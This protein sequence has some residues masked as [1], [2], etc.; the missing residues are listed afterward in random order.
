MCPR[1]SLIAVV[2]F[3]STGLLVHAQDKATEQSPATV[4]ARAA[5]LKWINSYA[6]VQVLFH[7]KDVERVR[8]KL[9][10]AS[11]EQAQQWL[12]ETREIREALDSARWKETQNWLRKF[13]EVQAIYSDEHIDHFRTDT[14][15]VA[16]ESKTGDP[17][18]FIE[19]LKDIEKKRLDLVQGAASS[20]RIR[21]QTNA[22]AQ[23]YR[24]EQAKA[25]D[26]ARL[27]TARASAQN[28]SSQP[29]V[30]RREYQRPSKMIDS[31]DVARWS[32]MR[33]FWPNRW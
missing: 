31:L 6:K 21:E 12:V 23:A 1:Q 29:P 3:V 14:E 33:G 24:K 27:A 22:M 15:K 28:R 4:D 16:K 13:L 11:P 32:V 30:Q 9:S 26:A 7:K 10:Q 2:L 18:K 5:A 8:E 19:I 17:E 20:A 25:R